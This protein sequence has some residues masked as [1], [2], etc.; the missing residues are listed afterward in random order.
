M[1]EAEK[2]DNYRKFGIPEHASDSVKR[3][4]LRAGMAKE[5]MLNQD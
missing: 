4:L 2:L 1:T 3:S 5:G